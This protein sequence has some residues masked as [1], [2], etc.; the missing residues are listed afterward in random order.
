MK[1][2]RFT[3]AVALLGLMIAGCDGGGI[4][5]G[6]PPEAPKSGMTPQFEDFMKKNAGNM[7]MPKSKPKDAPKAG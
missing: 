6:P 3:P 2:F 4:K 5:E 1:W 7:S